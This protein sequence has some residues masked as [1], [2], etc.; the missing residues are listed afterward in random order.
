MLLREQAK[1]KKNLHNYFQT[2][3]EEIDESSNIL[4]IRILKKN[5]QFFCIIC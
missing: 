5:D 2:I 1:L 3:L 4:E